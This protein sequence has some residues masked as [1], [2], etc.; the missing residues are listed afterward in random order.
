MLLSELLA[1]LTTKLAA[2]GLGAK[3]TLGLGIASVAV[4]GAGAA[5]VLPDPAQ[6]AVASVV[7][8]VSPLE[9]P[10]PNVLVDVDAKAKPSALDSLVTDQLGDELDKLDDELGDELGE[11]EGDGQGGEGIK[12]NHG[13]CVSAIAKNK[14]EG[15]TGRE[16]GLAVSTMAR[17]DCGKE[18]EGTSGASNTG[19]T[20]TTS[21]TLGT[22]NAGQ[23]GEDDNRGKGKSG[24]NNAGSSQNRGQGT[25]NGNNGGRGNS[26]N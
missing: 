5:N 26:G 17:S 14:A 10:D 2:L 7:N 21:T 6:H 3:A 12:D 1:G 22:L 8:A 16:H 19:S 24:E 11:D 15:T 9:L 23:V 13:A 18:D 20:T 4:T 25:N